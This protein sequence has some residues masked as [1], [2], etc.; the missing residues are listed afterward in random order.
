MTCFSVFVFSSCICLVSG[1]AD[2]A[3]RVRRS[4]ADRVEVLLG[5]SIAPST[6]G[7]YTALWRRWEAY[8]GEV[9]AAP[10]PAD[11]SVFECF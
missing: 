4:D 1:S 5:Q 9:G 8:C 3:S 11:P 7:K 6:R 2:G 10:L